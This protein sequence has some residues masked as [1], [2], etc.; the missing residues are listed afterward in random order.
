LGEKAIIGEP[1]GAIGEFAGAIGE[2]IDAIGE[3]AGDIGE[4]I[5]AIG[6]FA[7]DIG[8]PI[9]IIGDPAGDQDEFPR[10][11]PEPR[12]VEVLN[13]AIGSNADGG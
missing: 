12:S 4:P 10:A 6:E 5:G 7:G 9:G 11:A 1:I 3:F 8:P 13:A 2:P